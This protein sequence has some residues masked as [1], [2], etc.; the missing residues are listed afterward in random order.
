MLKALLLFWFVRRVFFEPVLSAKAEIA[1]K[2][3]Q[4]VAILILSRAAQTFR[5]C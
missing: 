4:Q 5:A 3:G 2:T 1:P